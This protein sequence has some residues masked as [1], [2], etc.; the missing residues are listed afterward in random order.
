M[1]VQRRSRVYHRHF[2]DTVYGGKRKALEA[3]KSYRNSLIARLRPLTRR[4]ACEF[5]KKNNRS[6]VSGVT[7]IDIVQTSRGWKYR[8]R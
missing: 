6:G 3:A 4:E 2:T 5:R 8:R 1:T 7:R